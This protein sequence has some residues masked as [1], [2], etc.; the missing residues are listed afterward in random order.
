MRLVLPR[1]YVILDAAL[2]TFPERDCALSLAEAGVRLL[3]YRNKSAPARQYL[4]SSR[5]LAELLDS[6][7]VTFFVNDRPDIAF[8]AGANGVH[9][10]QEDLDVEQARRIAGHD[11]LVGVST[12]NI[13]QFER[14]AASSAD[15]VAVGPVFPTSSKANPDPVVGLDFLRKVRGLT[16]K[17]LVAIGGITLE[18]AAS[19]VEAG[20]DSVAVISGILNS[21]DP[22]QRAR[23][24]NQALAGA[25][26]AATI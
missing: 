24:Y 9:V 7:G 6:L 10:G 3:Q 2:I 16:E 26:R 14:A 11:K 18:R 25:R 13:E 21:A 17:P 19:A 4:D 1:L 8:L 22:G 20:A 23:E 15:Y 5:Q 12:H